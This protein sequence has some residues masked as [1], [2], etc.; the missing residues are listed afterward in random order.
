MTAEELKRNQLV[1][2]KSLMVDISELDDLAKSLER[3]GLDQAAKEIYDKVWIMRC[4]VRSL[5]STFEG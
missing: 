3:V 4:T 2:T 1:Y 5:E